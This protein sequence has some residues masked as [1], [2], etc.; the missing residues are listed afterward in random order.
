MPPTFDQIKA[1]IG[2][3]EGS[4]P[5]MYVDTKGYVTVGIGNMLPNAGAAQQLAFVNRASG[6]TASAAE[7]ATDFANVAKQPKAKAAR[8][9][10]QFTALDL[11]DPEVD[12]LFQGRVEEF[13]TQLRREYPRYDSYPDGAQLAL[14]D[15]AFNLGAGALKT[16]WPKLN[17]A[18]DSLD[19]GAA[20]G[21]CE[22]PEANPARNAAVKALF[23]G[24]AA[25]R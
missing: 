4:I 10:E 21:E 14:L 5:F 7:V 22:R 19:W 17:Q 9:Y 15:M 6:S 8:W 1:L 16:K 24:A 13:Q 12:R 20:A 25:N 2:P 3:F 23:E 18:I 11:P